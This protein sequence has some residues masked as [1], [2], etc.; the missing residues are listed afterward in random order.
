MPRELMSTHAF[1]YST[2]VLVLE[3]ECV[4][5]TTEYSPC[6]I[7]CFL[8]TPP[9]FPEYSDCFSWNTHTPVLDLVL[10]YYIRFI[11]FKPLAT[12]QKCTYG[13]LKNEDTTWFFP[14][15]IQ[16]S[17]DFLSSK[18]CKIHCTNTRVGDSTI[19]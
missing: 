6:K 9:T 19:S 7:L 10:L 2:V 5:T 16:K 12:E 18:K 8:S 14:H 4:S 1:E 3:Y 15:T 17:L 13:N 11:Y